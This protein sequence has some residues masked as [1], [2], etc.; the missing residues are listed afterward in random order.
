MA[1][2]ETLPECLGVN[3]PNFDFAA[4]LGKIITGFLGIV[5]EIPLQLLT[6]QA[7]A[8]I[9]PLPNLKLPQLIIQKIVLPAFNVD[10]P[11]TTFKIDF[12][13]DY[14]EFEI[15]KPDFSFP[16]LPELF[17]VP[18]LIFP[19]VLIDFVVGLIKVVAGLPK[20]LLELPDD[21][22]T[23][24]SL[25][26]K[27]QIPIPDFILGIDGNPFKETFSL[28]LAKQITNKLGL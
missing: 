19:V 18:D 10:I 26:I 17:P 13:G 6:L 28:C 3:Q 12:L 4:S 22:P 16:D 1:E 23:A 27:D 9:D 7:E 11:L 24:I 25:V 2:E 15:G 21:L 14:G 20:I 5:P 8:N